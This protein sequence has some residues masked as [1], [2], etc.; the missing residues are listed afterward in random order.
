MG[1]TGVPIAT[2]MVDKNQQKIT[3]VFILTQQQNDWLCN[4]DSKQIIVL[5]AIQLGN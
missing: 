2:T 3:D 1:H 4:F 5:E